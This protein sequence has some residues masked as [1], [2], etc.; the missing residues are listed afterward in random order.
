MSTTNILDL[1]NRIDALE[2]IAHNVEPIQQ[3]IDELKAWTDPGTKDASGNPIILTDGAELEPTALTVTLEESEDG[4][5]ACTVSRDSK[6]LLPMVLADIKSANTSGTWN[7]NV[8][9]H[10]GVVFT[11]NT[12]D[13]DNIVGI[14]ANGTATANV[15]FILAKKQRL[16]KLASGTYIM[17]GCPAGGAPDGTTYFLG[18][19][20]PNKAAY[21]FGSGANISL[22]GN[23]DAS[24]NIYIRIAN[25]Y[26]AN[27]FTFYPMVRLASESDASFEPYQH[28]TASISF[29]ETINA[30]SVDFI[31]G[32]VTVTE[33]EAKTLTLTPDN[34]TLLKGNNV[35]R[36]AGNIDISYHPNLYSAELVMDNRI[37]ALEEKISILAGGTTG[38]VLTKTS[39]D[40]YDATWAA[41]PANRT[42][43][44]KSEK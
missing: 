5:S 32:I 30:G 13:G 39:N 14:K 38:Q 37:A 36:S 16:D 24:A 27:N 20:A 28:D 33:P 9:T 40:N 44:K 12:D 2:K 25:G 31:T 11:L 1:N 15:N 35:I 18:F 7:D 29:G 41:L 4:Y 21:D 34:I 22:S 19:Y 43:T 42:T 6:N 17:N 8:Y 3:Q 10:N 23:E 26:T